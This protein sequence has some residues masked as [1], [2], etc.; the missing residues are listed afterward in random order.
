MQDIQSLEW[1]YSVEIYE[2]VNYEFGWHTCGFIKINIYS[3]PAAALY[4]IYTSLLL[5]LSLAVKD[6]EH[7]L[8]NLLLNKFPVRVNTVRQMSHLNTERVLGK[9]RAA[10]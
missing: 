3:P 5:S 4:F 10:F 8:V 1:A 6:Y 9:K 2:S 7:R